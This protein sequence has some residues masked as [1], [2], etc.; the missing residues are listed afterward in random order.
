MHI[1]TGQICAA[2]AVL[3]NG[4]APIWVFALASP[5]RAFCRQAAGRVRQADYILVHHTASVYENAAR[6]MD[7]LLQLTHTRLWS[8]QCRTGRYRVV[9]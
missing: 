2:H 1:A 5:V 4:V 3:E 9:K 7:E 6:E 8:V